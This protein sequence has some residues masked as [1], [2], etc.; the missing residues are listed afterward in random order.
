MITRF[1]G[2]LGAVE[3]VFVALLCGPSLLAQTQYGT[4][5]WGADQGLPQNEARGICQTPEGYLWIA[6]LDGLAR[7]DGVRFVVFTRSNTPGIISNRFVSM[8]S[9]VGGDLWLLT[10]GGALTR[11][12]RGSF[13]S[14]RPSDLGIQTSVRALSSDGRGHIWIVFRE[15]IFQWNEGTAH[16]DRVYTRRLVPYRPIAWDGAGFWQVDGQQLICFVQGR[17]VNLPL[18]A[19]VAEGAISGV[20]YDEETRQLWIEDTAGRYVSLSSGT[21]KVYSVPFEIRHVDNS[22]QEWVVRV[23]RH[24]TRSLMFSSLNSNVSLD[25]SQL[26]RDRENNLWLTTLDRGIVQLHRASVNTISV[27]QGLAARNVYPIFAD[28]T[29][30]IWIGSWPGLTRWQNGKF[31]QFPHFRDENVSAIGEDTDGHVWVAAGDKLFTSSGGAFA[32]AVRPLIPPHADIAVIFK[33]HEGHLWFGANAGLVEYGNGV[34]RL[35]TAKD[36]LQ[37]DDVRVILE[38]HAGALWVAG[39]GGVTRIERGAYRRWSEKDGLPSESI[40]ALY[41]DN[42]GVMWIGT[43]DSGLIRLTG[44]RITRF[45]TQNGLFDNGVF[46]IIEDQSGF[47]WMTSNRGIYRVKKHELDDVAAGLRTIVHSV[48]YG[49]EDGMLS[50]GCNGGLSPAGVKAADGRIWFPTQNGVAVINPEELS[51][52]PSPA[53]V[54]LEDI[55]VDRQQVF[56]PSSLHIPPN[57]QNLEIHYTA[58]SFL[59]PE[60]LTFRYRLKGLDPDWVA[61]GTRRVAYYSHLPPGSYTFEVTA[62]NSEG[63]WNP[64]AKSL[65]VLIAAPFYRTGWFILSSGALLLALMAWLLRRRIMQLQ[66]EKAIQQAFSQQ[67]IASQEKERQRIASDLHDGLGQRLVVINNLALLTMQERELE[68]ADYDPFAVIEEIQ[69]E[70][71]LA[72]EETR[73]ISYNLRPFQ[74]DRLGLSKAIEAIARA[75]SRSSGVQIT[76]DLKNLDHAVPEAMRI[77]VFRIVQE[78]LNNMA[79]Y[80]NATAAHV[81]VEHLNGRMILTVEDNGMGFSPEPPAPSAGTMGGGLGLPGM[82]ER[83]TLL[84][85]SLRVQSQPNQGTTVILDL[86]DAAPAASSIN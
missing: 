72:I 34:T 68:N 63:V 19:G 53:P 85:G 39:T 18:P 54:I 55:F 59:K 70:A 33:D 56:P 65:Q 25:F 79:K 84:G 35:L 77:N 49:K 10:E 64:K 66:H 81:G 76:T 8:Y 58:L 5:T 67:L 13:H 75:V 1:R 15:G 26:F 69:A 37:T 9:G 43:Y 50:P 57:R 61:V 78:A 21:D 62:A 47:L 3:V 6:T 22:G 20:A 28:S 86:P 46:Q 24:F 16:F 42:Q 32:P 51:A 60:Q 4:R 83:A 45:T 38:D 7:F 52:N 48:A 44:E 36:G 11:Y 23:G 14:F 17:F 2:L 74:L 31:V 40:R 27:E 41:E 80:A 73:N 71:S 29:G 30:A 82:A 12:H